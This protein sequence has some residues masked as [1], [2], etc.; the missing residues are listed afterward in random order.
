[1]TQEGLADSLGLTFQQ[2]QKYETGRSRLSAGRLR[3]VAVALGKPV[4]YFYE[5]FPVPPAAHDLE[6][7][8]VRLLKQDAKKL[9]E[10]LARID[11]LEVAIHVLSALVPPRR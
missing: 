7:A 8:K 1:M 5:P 10:S 11:D 2:V 6:H 3:E 9:V 4:S